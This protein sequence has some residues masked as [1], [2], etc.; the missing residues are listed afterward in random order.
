MP[1]RGATATQMAQVLHFGALP[2]APHQAFSE[3]DNHLRQVDAQGNV[4]LWFPQRGWLWGAPDVYP[5]FWSASRNRWLWHYR[6][7]DQN[8]FLDY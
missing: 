8:T 4:R 7:D 1:A 2:G 5:F 6:I 3:L